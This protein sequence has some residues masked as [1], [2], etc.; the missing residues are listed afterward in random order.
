MQ[1][2]DVASGIRKQNKTKKTR[3]FA[4]WSTVSWGKLSALSKPLHVL[5][6]ERGTV[7]SMPRDADRV[8]IIMYHLLFQS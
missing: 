5:T 3:G 8:V 4:S 2:K 1:G 6:Y 7:I